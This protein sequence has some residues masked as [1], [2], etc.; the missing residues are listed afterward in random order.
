MS[1]RY[2][3]HHHS[4]QEADPI[5][6]L[7]SPCSGTP[8]VAGGPAQHYF[9]PENNGT[10]K[11]VESD[12]KGSIYDVQTHEGHVQ[13]QVAAGHLNRAMKSRHIQVR[14]PRGVSLSLPVSDGRQLMQMISI[15][16]VI[17]TG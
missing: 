14:F 17:G 5:A 13:D 16:G 8:D 9:P 4:A 10:S 7:F 12:Q 11:E 2:Q 1:S 6:T 3:L 15:G